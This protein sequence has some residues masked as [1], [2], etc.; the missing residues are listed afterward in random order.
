MALS[1]DQTLAL[2]QL[3]RQIEWFY[4]LDQYTNAQL[5]QL[6]KA[7]SGAEADVLARIADAASNLPNWSEDRAVSLLNN[8]NNLTVGIRSI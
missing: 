3:S 6:L 7:V 4:Q 8:F 2:I 5:Q 1:Y